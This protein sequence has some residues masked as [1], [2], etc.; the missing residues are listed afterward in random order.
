MD[1]LFLVGTHA[2]PWFCTLL[3]KS[4]KFAEVQK[5][6]KEKEGVLV[7]RAGQ[8]ESSSATR[9]LY[10]GLDFTLGSVLCTDAK[11]MRM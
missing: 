9:S 5:P 4:P 6:N 11:P 1:F 8:W 7:Q 2:M 3:Y 10:G